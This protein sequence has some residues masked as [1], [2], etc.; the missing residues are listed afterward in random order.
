[1]ST[2][3]HETR[4]YPDPELLLTW[5]TG[6]WL[7]NIFLC[8]GLSGTWVV[9]KSNTLIELRDDWKPSKWYFSQ[10]WSRLTTFYSCSQKNGKI[11]KSEPISSR[12]YFTCWSINSLI[13]F[14]LAIIMCSVILWL[15]LLLLFFCLAWT[16]MNLPVLTSLKKLL[17]LLLLLSA[18]FFPY[19][20]SLKCQKLLHYFTNNKKKKELKDIM[21]YS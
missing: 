9:K 4:K 16:R 10:P 20:R 12:I 15:S 8:F 3:I 14:Q 18:V 6:F 21:I 11:E 5:S 7:S 19:Q 17:P 13:T 1:M 2:G